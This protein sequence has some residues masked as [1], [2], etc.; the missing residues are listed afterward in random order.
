M[1]FEVEDTHLTG[2][3]HHAGPSSADH[4]DH[5]RI[6]FVSRVPCRSRH[7]LSENSRLSWTPK[8]ILQA[9]DLEL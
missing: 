9:V 5:R 8:Q 6:D 7:R 4:E 2:L 1:S 3:F